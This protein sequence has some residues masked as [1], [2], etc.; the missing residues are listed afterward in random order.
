MLAIQA[1]ASGVCDTMNGVIF[2]QFS[3]GQGIEIR[4]FRSRIGHHL[5]ESCLVVEQ[6]S[7]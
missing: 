4:E 1:K 6:F 3:L 5:P 2:K 7:L